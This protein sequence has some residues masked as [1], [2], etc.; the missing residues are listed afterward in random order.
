MHRGRQDQHGR[1]KK[2]NLLHQNIVLVQVVRT[3]L[4]R[5]PNI[6][7]M[8]VVYNFKSG[9]CSKLFFSRTRKEPENLFEIEKSSREVSEL[10]CVNV[11]GTEV[12]F[13]EF[14]RVARDEDSSRNLLR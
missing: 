3:P 5:D 7:A 9:V 2:E 10:N 8:S 4:G 13:F 12:F 14:E 1:K 11:T 6:V